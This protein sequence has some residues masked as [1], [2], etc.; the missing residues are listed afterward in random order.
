MRDERNLHFLRNKNLV[1]TS[2][3]FLLQNYPFKRVVYTAI[4]MEKDSVGHH[5]LIF[6]AFKIL[7]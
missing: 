1:V 3:A 4:V 7:N 6:Q 2:D 5:A